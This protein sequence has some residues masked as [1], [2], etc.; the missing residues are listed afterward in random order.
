MS[1]NPI[2]FERR[3]GAIADT[4]SSS[5]YPYEPP[6]LP[7]ILTVSAY[8][9]LLN[10]SGWLFDRLIH[11]NLV[12]QILI[13]IV[14][15]P[16]LANILPTAWIETF[17]SLGY[18][19]LILIVFQGGL[20]TDLSLILPTIGLSFTV[21]MTGIGVPIALSMIYIPFALNYSALQ[22]FASGASLSS[23]SLGTT[24]AVLTSES[25]GPVDIRRSRLGTV[26]LTAAIADDVVGLVLAAIIPSLGGSS[27]TAFSWRTI[28][29]PVLTSLAFVV[30]VP[31]TSIYAINPS[32][33]WVKQRQSLLERA[34]RSAGFRSVWN[35]ARPD[36]F[37]V[38]I[39]IMVLAGF[40]AGAH[41]AGTSELL[42][43]YIAGC[44]LGS[45][46]NALRIPVPGPVVGPQSPQSSGPAIH[47]GEGTQISSQTEAEEPFEAAFNSKIAPVLHRVLAPLFFASIGN[48]I[49]FVKLWSPARVVWQGFVYAMLMALA[50]FSAGAWWVVWR[51]PTP[52]PTERLL[53]GAGRAR[54]P[55]PRV[56]GALFLGTALIARGEIAL[57]VASLA[58]SLLDKNPAG[59]GEQ[60]E[61]YAVVMWAVLACTVGGAV[62]VG[63][64]AKEAAIGCMPVTITETA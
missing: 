13:G 51:H 44:W 18:V 45:V 61:L 9:Y 15:G 57:L 49:P 19:G 41:Y 22:G 39:D 29:R 11:A 56:R 21:A 58:R 27:H 34:R 2:A 60:E 17:T 14:F 32:I 36:D 31:V 25:H 37:V 30:C 55:S 63:V 24:L 16:P 1:L 12:G 40:V 54:E 23:T 48:S 3:A 52:D 6:T 46:G 43:A 35:A 50:K 47:G 8:L 53:T 64:L 7:Q 38:A 59:S 33:R 26:L 20:T 5:I 10:V 62:G 28:V 4:P 42:G